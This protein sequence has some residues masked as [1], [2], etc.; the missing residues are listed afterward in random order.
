MFL[1]I[2]LLGQFKLLAGDRPLELPSRPA[3]SLFAYL[4]LNPGVTQ[5]REKL[6]GLLWPEASESNARGYLRQALWRIRKSLEGGNLN[7]DD[8]LQVS[9]INVT[10]DDQ[11]DYWL[12]AGQLLRAADDWPLEEIIEIARLYRGELLPGFYEEWVEQE[13][14]RLVAAYQ[15]KMNLL[16]ERLLQ[17]GRWQEALEWGEGWIRLGY[18][19]EAAFRAL[20]R[21]HAGLGDQG[22]VSATYQRCVEALQRELGLEPS[23]ETQRLYEQKRRGEPDR[24]GRAAGPAEQRPPFLD[25]GE[26][27][28]IEKPVF[29]AR[30]REL[31]Q[32]DRFLDLAL[33]GHGRVVFV[34]GEVGSGK[35][36]LVQEFTRRIQ[37]AHADPS[38]ISGQALIV[39]S[40]N[41][42]AYTGIGDPYLPFREILELL[43]GDVEARWVAGT[44]TTQHARRLWSTLPL[45]A[46]ALVE[47]GPD[48]I[49]TFV[50][51][52]ALLERTTAGAPVQAERLAR[53]DGLAERKPTGLG[54]PSL[55]QSDL[56][57]QYSRALQ[58]LAR[59]VSL[60]LV[61]DDLQWADLGSISLLF[62][63]G[64]RLAGSRI[65]LVGA[66]R[67][68][69][70]A[71]GR[72]GARHPL[73]PVVNELQRELGDIT[74][75]LGQAESRDFMEAL[76]DSE[77]NRLGGAFRDMLYRQTRGQPLFTVELL[78]GLQER[79]DLVR[80]P[81][82]QWVE[83]PALDWERLPAR[84][85]AV[86]AER[87]GRLPQTLR[88][89][90]SIAS[91]EGE[92]F[93][94]EVAARV[95]TADEQELLRR[96]SSEVDRRHRL[97]RAQ[98]IERIEGQILSRYRFRHILF[99]RYLYSSLDEVE[100]V[101]LHEQVGTA[102][103]ELYGERDI[104][105]VAVQL[106]LHFQKAGITQKAIHYLHQAGEK[107]LQMSAY[108]EAIAH[109]NTGLALLMSLPDSG[110]E[111]QN[112]QR[113]EQELA[114]QISLGIAQ[115]RDLPDPGAEKALTRACQL[116]Q[117]M[118]KTTQLCRVMGELSIFPYVRAE[119]QKA[120]KLAEEALSL[121]QEAGDAL[122]EVLGHWQLG[123]IQFGLGEYTIAR[124]H[125]Q[126]MI[127]FY[128]PRQHHHSF[129]FLRGSDAGVSA[130]AYDACCLWCLGYPEQAY[131]RSQQALVLARK[132]NH[133]FSLADVL[134][135]GGCLFNKMRRD[136]GALEQDAQELTHLS[137]GMGFLSFLWTGACYRGEA[138]TRLGQVQE[139]IAQ[140]R[141]GMVDRQSIGARCYLS[142]I[143][144]A[145]AEAQARPG[146][147]KEGLATLAEAF[148]LVAETDERYCEAE[149]HRLRAE[150]L[151]MQGDEAAAEASLEQAI[152]AA[153]RQ[154]ARSWELRAA[155]GLAR[156]R[157]KQGRTEEARQFLGE[158]YSW[159]TEGFDTPDLREARALLEELA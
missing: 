29:V 46:Q 98:S 74:V 37:E 4:A 157:Q 115:K 47:A 111:D 80:D 70:I 87:I 83:G 78:R 79:G 82:G 92:V 81:Q 117:Q 3:Q 67:P 129:V 36:A 7:G 152:A 95:R 16:L 2:Y 121:A 118:G 150:L 14:I 59:K 104:A 9:D 52:A 123:Y 73:E 48:L 38:R 139:G 1:K 149:L 22:M 21:A 17:A 55:Q 116:C 12:D 94:A 138:L 72:D 122:L 135:F 66:Y 114:L 18:S 105:A 39:A 106:A 96:L 103:E 147:A 8:Y 137:E 13:R 77:P 125:L 108:Q 151:L 131:R 71:L 159:F 120:R 32:L 93:T 85:E 141:Q 68:E 130:L 84:V 45:A 155:T 76:L 146:R 112:L 25:G 91:V 65:L 31:A 10:F 40:G 5:R 100:R 53:L 28:Q 89:L 15:Q 158:V 110:L 63:I 156:L 140:M 119:Y 57:E 107:A 19:P 136:W 61:V 23:P 51:R 60:V 35:T 97:V 88:D 148:A 11:S 143:L 90:L 54:T 132:L 133:A 24:P 154:E 64:R 144:G 86:V 142:G 101:H 26:T 42:N 134:C 27:R 113:A 128:E 20:M 109:L 69:E 41:C 44:I 6:A 56:F 127:S 43:T 30:E 102:L 145:L 126:Q 75:N 49:D 99:Q 58:A 62:H 34:T 50:P 124:V 33:S 153:R